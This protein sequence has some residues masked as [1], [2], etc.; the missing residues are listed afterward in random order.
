MDLF[1]I[2]PGGS[3]RI[4]TASAAPVVSA[5]F[6]ISHLPSTGRVPARGAM[7]AQC[8]LEGFGAL[9]VRGLV[10]DTPGG[11]DAR[12]NGLRRPRHFCLRCCFPPCWYWSHSRLKDHVGAMRVGWILGA[13]CAPTSSGYLRGP[14]AYQNGLRRSRH[15]RPL[16][17]PTLLVPVGFPLGGACWG[18]ARRRGTGRWVRIDFFEVLAVAPCASARNPLL[19]SVECSPNA[20]PIS[21]DAAT[22][23]EFLCTCAA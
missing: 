2:P 9:R 21:S 19:L 4:R 11:R 22:K 6:A 10:E 20:G 15:F 3:L 14:L 16:L 17:L 18:E 1:S 23:F 13:E 8:A 7:L 12:Q 5:F